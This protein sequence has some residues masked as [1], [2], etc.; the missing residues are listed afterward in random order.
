MKKIRKHRSF[1]LKL[2]AK[3]D[4]ISKATLAE[5]SA[6][7]EILF[8]L[9]N[10]PFTKQEKRTITKHLAIIREIAKCS[11]EKKARAGLIQHGG[12]FLGAVVP[13]ALA[14]LLSSIKS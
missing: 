1:L 9:G 6:V 2:S 8:N 10:I 13:A 3:P 5:L 7:V 11:R 4:I 14:L 12:G